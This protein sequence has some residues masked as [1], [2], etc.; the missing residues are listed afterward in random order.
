MIVG[1]KY[2]VGFLNEIKRYC[3]VET[4]NGYEDGERRIFDAMHRADYVFMLV[5]SVPHAMTVYTK[6]TK[7]LN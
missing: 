2:S 4:F 6:G 5:G 1:N 3:S 7:D